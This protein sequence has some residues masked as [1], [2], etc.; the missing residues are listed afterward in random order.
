[1]RP[2]CLF[3]RSDE[4][5][6][7]AGSFAEHVASSFS[8][9]HAF[10]KLCQQVSC[11]PCARFA[12]F[13]HLCDVCDFLHICKITAALEPSPLD[14]EWLS[15]GDRVFLQTL[16]AWLRLRY[17]KAFRFAV[18]NS[19]NRQAP[20]CAVLPR[21]ANEKFLWRKVFD[22]NPEIALASDKLKVKG[23]V[24]GLCPN[25]KAAEVLW[26][27]TD[28]ADI[29]DAL[30]EQDVI[31]KCN[32]SCNDKTFARD[33]RGDRQGFNRHMR[34]QMQIDH[35]RRFDEWGYKDIKRKLFVERVL[36]TPPVAPTQFNIFFFG[37]VIERVGILA[38]RDGVRYG[39]TLQARR[40]GSLDPVRIK[41][42]VVQH[43]HEDPIPPT[44]YEAIEA[45]RTIAKRFDHVR[46]DFM[47]DGT[48]LWIGELTFYNQ[49]GLLARTGD[50]L[51]SVASRFWDLRKS[52]FL[53]A[54]AHRGVMRRYARILTEFCAR[55]A[56][57]E[58]PDLRIPRNI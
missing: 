52:H 32:H 49:A 35:Y 44:F 51:Q 40:D 42:D 56:E 13:C 37:A 34:E 38:L 27:G 47:T 39:A 57:T 30:L 46:T 23:F 26:I 12:S 20:I 58:M 50:D 28:P 48:S 3:C 10:R 25:V 45:G 14:A 19:P 54:R 41:P 31:A 4:Y 6:L 18:K 21:T 15:S 17:R 1:M 5:L 8:R 7:L 33:C 9:H 22:R 11:A 2:F 55:T 36:G 43:L 29:P 53:N 16:E 24:R